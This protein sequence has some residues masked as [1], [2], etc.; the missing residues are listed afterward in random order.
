MPGKDRR[1]GPG[2]FHGPQ[3]RGL[4]AEAGH[5]GRHEEPGPFEKG[6]FR[7]FQE[8]IL[9]P[10][11]PSNVRQGF[12]YE[13]GSRDL[14]ELSYASYLSNSWNLQAISPSPLGGRGQGEGGM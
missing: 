8:V 9:N 12:C 1:R 7:G 3:G 4:S 11:C 14:F 2:P 6:G 5:P 10:P 13:A